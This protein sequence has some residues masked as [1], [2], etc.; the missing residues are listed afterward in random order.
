MVY[1]PSVFNVLDSGPC[2]VQEESYFLLSSGLG[3]L[4][5][6]TA[7]AGPIQGICRVL[8]VSHCML[9]AGFLRIQVGTNL[10]ACLSLARL[11]AAQFISVLARWPSRPKSGQTEEAG[12]QF[13]VWPL[14]SPFFLELFS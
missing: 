6:C 4:R 9:E 5:A 1:S 12:S 10:P 11:K 14:V 3:P 8:M 7:Q 13:V 2:L